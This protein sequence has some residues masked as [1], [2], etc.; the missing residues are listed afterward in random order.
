MTKSI[1][2]NF[3]CKHADLFA[4]VG[5]TR[6]L[7]LNMHNV[8]GIGVEEEIII[9]ETFAWKK[10][11]FIFTFVEESFVSCETKHEENVIEK[12]LEEIPYAYYSEFR[13]LKDISKKWF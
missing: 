9:I 7:Y 11:T 12:Y 4:N 10:R 6:G 13:N 2:K 8:G 5:L 1:I 3:V